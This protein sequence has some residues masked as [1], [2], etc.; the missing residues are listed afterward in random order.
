M[1]GFPPKVRRAIEERSGG[2][3]EGCGRRPATE[4]HHRKYRSR[5]GKDTVEN[6]YHLCGFGNN[7][8]AGC[9]GTAHSGEGGELGW[10]VNSWGDPKLTPVL[11]RGVLRWLTD[12]G[13]AVDVGPEP[14]F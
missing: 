5:G 6:G 2:V 11:Y 1:A 4:M 9:H 7:Q 3:C 13:R 8:T 14:N 10:S 12:D